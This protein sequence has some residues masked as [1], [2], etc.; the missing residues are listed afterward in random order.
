[1]LE[2]RLHRIMTVNKMQFG[3]KSEKGRIDVVLGLRRMQKEYHGK[4]KKLYMCFV[5][6]NKALHRVWR[7]LLELAMRQK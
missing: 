5:D 6:L 3:L 7:K 4:R 2:K 1:M